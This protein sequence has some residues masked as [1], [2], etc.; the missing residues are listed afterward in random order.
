MAPRNDGLVTVFELALGPTTGEIAFTLGLVPM[1]RVAS[2]SCALQF[3]ETSPC[4]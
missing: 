3:G 1:N 2:D 4:A